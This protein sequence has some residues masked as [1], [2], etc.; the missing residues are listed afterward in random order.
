M[1]R[2]GKGL[3]VPGVAHHLIVER[4][5][6]QLSG[7]EPAGFI[8][9][10][11]HRA[12]DSRDRSHFVGVN[13]NQVFQPNLVELVLLSEL[14]QKAVPFLVALNQVHGCGRLYKLVQAGTVTVHHT[15]VGDR[16]SEAPVQVDRR[17]PLHFLDGQVE[18]LVE[19][20]MVNVCFP[21]VHVGKN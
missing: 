9:G 13:D 1:H 14:G 11:F 20:L 7:I 6:C 16:I 19:G 3:S 2:L 15:S 5:P 12:H 17:L 18:R 4:Q 10:L 21:L 8:H